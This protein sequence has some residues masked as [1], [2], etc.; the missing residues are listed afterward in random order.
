MNVTAV[1]GFLHI[2]MV[3]ELRVAHNPEMS[4]QMWL[5]GQ[6]LADKGL[7]EWLTEGISIQAT[8]SNFA[9]RDLS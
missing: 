4:S 7:E 3:A 5:C 8:V 1:L 2:R 6:K 9:D